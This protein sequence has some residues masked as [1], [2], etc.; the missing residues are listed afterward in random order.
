MIVEF[1]NNLFLFLV[2]CHTIQLSVSTWRKEDQVLS[3]WFSLHEKLSR[4]IINNTSTKTITD[5]GRWNNTVEQ[6]NFLIYKTL[7][8]QYS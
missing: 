4:L 7:P 3:V 5:T 2:L 6:S 8:T 1:T